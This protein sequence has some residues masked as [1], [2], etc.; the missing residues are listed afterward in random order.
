PAFVIF[1]DATLQAIAEQEP[2]TAAQLARIS[3]VGE[4]KLRRYGEA[5][6]TLCAGGTP[7]QAISGLR[8]ETP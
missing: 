2:S 3:G 6:L 4:R 1:T 5:I 7:E 8:E